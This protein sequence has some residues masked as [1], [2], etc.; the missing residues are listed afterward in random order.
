MSKYLKDIEKLRGATIKEARKTALWR[1]IIEPIL[2]ST[3][4]YDVQKMDR[5]V[6]QALKDMKEGKTISISTK[7]ELDAHLKEIEESV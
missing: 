1:E 7:E 2:S 3:H 6:K 4:I 5:M